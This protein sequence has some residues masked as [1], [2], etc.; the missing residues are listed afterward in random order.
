VRPAL[1]LIATW[2]VG[3][4]VCTL[5]GCAGQQTKSEAPDFVDV[6]FIVETFAADGLPTSR[7][8]QITMLTTQVD[9][10][11]GNYVDPTLGPM[12]GP[13]IFDRDTPWTGDVVLG[14]GLVSASMTAVLFGSD[15]ESIHCRALADGAPL[16]VTDAGSSDAS[17]VIGGPAAATVRCFHLI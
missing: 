13:S 6:T 16:P 11:P 9:G 14:P 1:R 10:A 17:V 2:T 5:I 3:I 15:G 12:P 4:I 8:V 7:K